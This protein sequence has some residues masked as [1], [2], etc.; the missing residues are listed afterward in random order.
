LFETEYVTVGASYENVDG[1]N[2]NEN[3]WDTTASGGTCALM[4]NESCGIAWDNDNVP[5]METQ[6]LKRKVMLEERLGSVNASKAILLNAMLS[7]LAVCSNHAL[8]RYTVTK[9]LS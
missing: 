6:R 5:K 4:G 3:G 1:E 9:S 2:V 7:R 8:N